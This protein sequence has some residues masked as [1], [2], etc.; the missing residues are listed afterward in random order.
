MRFLGFMISFGAALLTIS[1]ASAQQK[2][3]MPTGLFWLSTVPSWVPTSAAN[4]LPVTC[5]SGC[6]GGGGG[7]GAVFGPTAAAS[8]AANPPVLIGGTVDGTATGNVDNWKVLNGI[9][10]VSATGPGAVAL[11]TAVNQ[12]SNAA[13]TAHTCSTGGFSELGCLGQI[14]DDIKSP[15]PTSGPTDCSGTIAIGGTAQQLIGAA[16]GMHGFQL[17]NLSPDPLAISWVT[18]TPAVLTPGSY[19][20]NSGSAS[21]AGGSY[22]SPLGLGITAAVYIVG[23][24]T[25]DAFSCSWW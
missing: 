18:V 2:V 21:A 3:P 22:Q 25:T 8:P 5:I 23:G 6:S 16:S 15:I 9:G 13:T 7:G 14:D 12:A 10:Y 17:Q 20:L 24:T 19:T 11:A 4:P 1:S